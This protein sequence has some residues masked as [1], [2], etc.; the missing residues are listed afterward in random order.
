LHALLLALAVS[1]PAHD[2][3]GRPCRWRAEGGITI[4]WHQSVRL[5]GVTD[6]EV[7]RAFR[8]AWAA[9]AEAADITP[10]EADTA[11]SANVYAEAEFI[12]GPGNVAAWTTLPCGAR[13]NRAR[14]WFDSGGR[15]DERTLR[16]VVVHEIGPRPRARPRGARVDDEPAL[17]PGRRRPDRVGPGRDRRPLRGRR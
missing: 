13:N 11:A 4:R 7:A 17:E 15:W 3:A 5:P 6:A 16:R 8:D 2:H 9:W 10:I 14:Q 12:D 1:L